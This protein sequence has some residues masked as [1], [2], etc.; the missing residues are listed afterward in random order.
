MNNWYKYM[1]DC[2]ENVR[3]E[4][5][6]HKLNALIIREMALCCHKSCHKSSQ[7]KDY[8]LWVLNVKL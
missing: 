4:L 6:C 5:S 8:F 1:F 2:L 3:L 7:V